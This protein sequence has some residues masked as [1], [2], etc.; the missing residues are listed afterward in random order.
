MS[1]IKSFSV[2]E[3]DMFY[4][5]HGSDNFTIIDCGLSDD[6]KEEIVEEI[7]IENRYKGVTRFI[8]THPDQDHIRGLKY[9]DDCI[10]ILNFYCVNN[11][12]IKDDETKDFKHYCQLRDSDKAFYISRDCKRRWMNKSNNERGS[13]GINILW[14]IEDNEHYKA[15]MEIAEKGGNANNISAII[16]YSLEDGVTVLWMGDLETTFLENI[17]DTIDWPKINILFAPH[18]GRESG[19]VPADILKKLDPEIIVIG[20]APADDLDY[21]DGYNTISQNSA[22]D[23]VCKCEDA[24]VHVFVSNENYSVGFFDD[25]YA[26]GDGNYIGTLNL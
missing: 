5:K 9:L 13:A 12:V 4:I 19:K 6:N 11:K 18:H 25:E 23:I 3:G 21:Y 24:Q 14:P 15:E 17:K 7:K 20:E 26:Y 2:D 10:N 1:T 22:G 8:S 16:K